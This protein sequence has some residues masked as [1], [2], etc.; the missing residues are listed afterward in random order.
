MQVILNCLMDLVVHLWLG[1]SCYLLFVVLC[2]L[3]VWIGAG[4]VAWSCIMDMGC[5]WWRLWNLPDGFWWLLSWLQNAGGWLPFEYAFSSSY[6]IFMRNHVITRC[7]S[8]GD[9]H[10]KLGFGCSMLAYQIEA[11][12]F[13]I[14]WLEVTCSFAIFMFRK[15][16]VMVTGTIN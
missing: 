4:Q 13:F 8:Y 9:W 5:T 15:V 6:F 1:C 2:L 7:F 16:I 10:G 14:D 12:L 3:V 11:A